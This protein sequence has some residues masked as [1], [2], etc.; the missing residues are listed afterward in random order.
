MVAAPDGPEFLKDEIARVLGAWGADDDPAWRDVL[1]ALGEAGARAQRGAREADEQRA[2]TARARLAALAQAP[3]APAALRSALA[4][5][6]AALEQE[7]PGA[8]DVERAERAAGAAEAALRHPPAGG[9]AVFRVAS[10]LAE[11]SGRAQA[12]GD[13]AIAS[14]LAR[15]TGGPRAGQDPLRWLVEAR[16]ALEDAAQR[17]AAARVR[18]VEPLR[19]CRVELE[20]EIEG[21]LVHASSDALGAAA[22]VV[23]ALRRAEV[24]GD[25]ASAAQLRERARAA[26]AALREPAPH[27]APAAEVGDATPRPPERAEIALRLEAHELLAAGRAALAAAK[28]DERGATGLATAVAALDEAFRGSDAAL[29]GRRTRELAARLPALRQRR[30]RFTRWIGA[31]AVI[32]VACAAALLPWW[33]GGSRQTVRLTLDRAPA[34]PVEVQLVGPRGDVSRHEIAAG[35]QGLAVELTPGTYEVF[36]D[37]G[38]SGRAVFVPGPAE[39]ALGPPL[40]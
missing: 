25:A 6:V 15:W 21:H 9:D 1:A 22:G 29:L 2:R 7:P 30:G 8:T 23:S 3:G 32:A 33:S 12:V 13:A 39:V 4:G 35:R 20:R 31:G 37:G 40:P 24:S 11:M 10:E 26:S 16:S 28:P 27:A 18:A 34:R 14:A 38:H 5:L 36:V 17:L 19:A